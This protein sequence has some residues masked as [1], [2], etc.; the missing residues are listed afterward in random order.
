MAE[1]EGWTSGKL[2]GAQPGAPAGSG[3]KTGIA[4]ACIQPIWIQ[5]VLLHV[6]QGKTCLSTG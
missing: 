4:L 1:R 3:V 5:L 2:Q 6:D